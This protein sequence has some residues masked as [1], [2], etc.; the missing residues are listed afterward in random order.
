[1]ERKAGEIVV[2]VVRFEVVEQEEGIEVVEVAAADRAP[3]V[4]AG[5]FHD[6]LRLD[7]P[8]DTSG[9]SVRGFALPIP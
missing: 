5:S 1:M 7:H 2:R 6:R 9:L 3:E 8:C 4:H